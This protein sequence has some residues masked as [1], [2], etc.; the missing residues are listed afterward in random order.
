M[1]RKE[2]VFKSGEGCR[3]KRR[4]LMQGR[5]EKRRKEEK[6]EKQT[7]S[8]QMRFKALLERANLTIQNPPPE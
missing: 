3:G 5:G 1:M 4:R 7:N 8:S 6:K 2:E